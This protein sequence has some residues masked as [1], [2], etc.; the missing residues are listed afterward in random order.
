MVGGPPYAPSGKPTTGRNAR[1][2]GRQ[3]GEAVQGKPPRRARLWPRLCTTSALRCWGCGVCE[4]LWMASTCAPL[5]PLTSGTS[6]VPLGT[7]HGLEPA[8]QLRLCCRKLFLGHDALM[9]EL[10]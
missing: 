2:R 9:P 10:G 4:G 6:P 7:P 8:E 5:C 3:C 1:T